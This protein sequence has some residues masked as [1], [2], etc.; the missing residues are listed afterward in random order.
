M[1]K[2]LIVDDSPLVRKIATDILTQDPEVTVVGTAS[3]AEIAL[4]RI[5]KNPPDVI[6]MDIE[7]PGMGGL[8]AISEIMAVS[9]TPI[10][11]LSA[12]A[13]RGAELTMQAL[14]LGAVDFIAK[15]AHS[16]SGGIGDIARELVEKVKHTAAVKVNRIERP[17][18]P[19]AA[20][21]REE[22]PEGER[23][24]T[25]EFPREAL[26]HLPAGLSHYDLVAI[27]TSTGGPVALKSVLTRLP[28]SFPAGIVIVQHMPPVFTNAFAARLDSLCAI[29]V[30]EA[31]DGDPILP[32]T[33]LVAPGD[34]HM[35]VTQYNTEP[36]VLL[37]KREP[38]NG[39]RPSVDVLVHSVAREYGRRAIGVI[40]T[41]MG[42]DGAEAMGELKGMGGCVIA[43]DRETSVIYGMNGEVV[44]N[45]DAD[46]VVPL[47]DI[48]ERIM[49]R[50]RA[51]QY[52]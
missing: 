20:P 16:L 25:E 38:V 21:E 51:K 9:P 15:P 45:G 50:L 36:K 28:K 6:T 44:R 2:V 39:H 23:S 11:V 33:A 24:R 1:I 48:P 43:Q 18:A 29:S 31:E 41:G 17:S 5:Q 19:A 52:A 34:F 47:G 49:E 30:K 42:K 13:K 3:N 40:M 7:M 22:T 14:D 46:E 10:I 4:Q 8:A 35:T 26:R 32:G 27:G 37:H 12:F